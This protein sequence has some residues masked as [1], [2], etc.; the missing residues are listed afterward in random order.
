M[1]ATALRALRGARGGGTWL[2]AGGTG[3]LRPAH[4]ARSPRRLSNSTDQI[5]GDS[6]TGALSTD[7]GSEMDEYVG[8]HRASHRVALRSRAPGRFTGSF[9]GRNDPPPYHGPIARLSSA[10]PHGGE[11]EPVVAEY[12]SSL[13][14][15]YAGADG[16]LG[17]HLLWDP[18]K[19]E[20]TSLTVWASAGHLS[21]LTETDDYGDTMKR[22]G[23][24]LVGVPEVTTLRVLASVTQEP[25]PATPASD[26]GGDAAAG[27]T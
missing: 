17:A 23:E 6:S 11:P 18:V 25:A 26:D 12:E 20:A 19:G 10:R 3:V 24:L 14:K 22:F 15:L 9:R 13:R 16:C 21:A 2:S 27:G 8:V 4:L 5:S 1:M 7:A